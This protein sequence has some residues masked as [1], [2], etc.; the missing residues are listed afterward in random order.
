MYHMQISATAYFAA[1]NNTPFAI[2]DYDYQMR[3]APA[4][5]TQ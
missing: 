4:Q 5:R 1:V 3:L 2:E